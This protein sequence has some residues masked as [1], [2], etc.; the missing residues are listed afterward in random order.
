MSE[1]KKVNE[2]DLWKAHFHGLQNA[3]KGMSPEQ[4]EDLGIWPT[5]KTSRLISDL[6]ELGVIAATVAR[7]TIE[8]SEDGELPPDRTTLKS[9]ER[10]VKRF[11][12]IT[13]DGKKINQPYWPQVVY[14]YR[15]HGNKIYYLES[16]E[17]IKDYSHE[18]IR[19]SNI[20]Q[21][22]DDLEKSIDEGK[23]KI[24]GD[25]PSDMNNHLY[26]TTD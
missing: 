11:R 3:P 16:E 2:Q 21:T 8:F 14:V 20:R 26:K 10:Q 23:G 5:P 9:G 18:S 15:T 1:E 22:I 6:K 17:P 25:K 12:K 7:D 19:E 4:L 24:I 13:K